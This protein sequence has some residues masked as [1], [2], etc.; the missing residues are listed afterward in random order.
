MLRIGNPNCRVRLARP[1]HDFMQAWCREGPVHHTALGLGDLGDAVESF[2]EA[3]GL[4][5]VRV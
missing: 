4:R 3:L 2:A 5:C 1:I